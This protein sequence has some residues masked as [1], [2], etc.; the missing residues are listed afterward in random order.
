MN[1]NDPD[2]EHIYSIENYDDP[3]D[4]LLYFPPADNH[5][6]G[7]AEKVVKVEAKK[8]PHVVRVGGER[9]RKVPALK[10]PKLRKVRS[11]KEAPGEAP[12]EACLLPMEEG[13]CVRF[14]LRWYFNSH[15]QACRPFIYSGCGGNDNRF[16]YLE[17]CEEVCLGKAQGSS[18]SLQTAR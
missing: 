6:D 12:A 15:V 14:T 11:P 3:L 16:V 5:T 13:S 9:G 4:E 17:E 18:P 2:Y 8:T 1:T 7:G 10:P